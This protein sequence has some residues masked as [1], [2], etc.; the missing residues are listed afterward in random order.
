M[1]RGLIDRTLTKLV[2]KADLIN[3][4]AGRE[5]SMTVNSANTVCTI[6]ITPKTITQN[7]P[8]IEMDIYASNGNIVIYADTGSGWQYKRTL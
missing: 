7:T 8:A 2:G 1:S 4:M 3:T 6:I 5:A